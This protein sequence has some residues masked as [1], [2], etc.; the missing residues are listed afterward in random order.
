MG[1]N[2]IIVILLIMTGFSLFVAIRNCKPICN[3]LVRWQ[4]DLVC[5]YNLGDIQEDKA[6]VIIVNDYNNN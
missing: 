1:K 3:D 6:D 5:T 2:I 4:N